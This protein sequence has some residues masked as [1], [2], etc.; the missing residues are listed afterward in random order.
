MAESNEQTW[1]YAELLANTRRIAQNLRINEDDIVYQYGDG[2]FE[3]ICGLMSTLCAGGTYVPLSPSMLPMQ[4]RPFIDEVHDEY[5]LLHGET[6]ETFSE[7][8]D[9]KLTFIHLDSIIMLDR[10][11]DLDEIGRFQHA[12]FWFQLQNRIAI[13]SSC[14]YKQTPSNF[15][16]P[17]FR[18]IQSIASANIHLGIIEKRDASKHDALRDSSRRH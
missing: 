14:P 4:I 5:I 7:V 12:D 2:S 9:E 1:S 6:K 8:I 13:V 11:D 3:V 18:F 17:S 15:Y 16:W 10:T